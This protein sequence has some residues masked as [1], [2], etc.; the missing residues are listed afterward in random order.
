MSPT[1]SSGKT[2]TQCGTYSYCG[3][4]QFARLSGDSLTVVNF[5]PLEDYVKGVLPNEMSA[6]WPLEALKAQAVCARTYA[7]MNQNR[8]RS[9]GFDL[10]D[11]INCQVYR[12]L[13]EATEQTNRAVDDTAG[14][15][16]RYDGKV[17]AVYY[18]A[19]D[20]GATED[21]ENVWSNAAIPYLRGVA[22]PYEADLDFYC[23]SWSIA[24]P[25][26]LTGDISVTNTPQGNIMTLTANGQTYQK[27]D[28]RA[29]LRGLG[30][31]YTS[32]RFS[33]AYDEET[34]SYL[35]SG[36]GYGH[37]LGMSQWGAYAMAERAMTYDQIISF[38]FTG[39]YVE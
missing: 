2:A 19:A 15:L 4:F 6:S 18:F 16:V 20:G 28:V 1:A 24:V 27:D 7:V 22:D 30:A 5:V 12:G 9:Y 26:A 13:Y 21:S 23:K 25:H 11:D 33:V 36:A 17:C 31:R 29:F 32:R 10:T 3:D 35:I 38:Y 39:A 37:Q 8:Y 14:E 34:D